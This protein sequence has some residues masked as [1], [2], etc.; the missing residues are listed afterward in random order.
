MYR[1]YDISKAYNDIRTQVGTGNVVAAGWSSLIIHGAA[2]SSCAMYF[3]VSSSGWGIL[4][5]DIP[6]SFIY[7]LDGCRMAKLPG[8]IW[9]YEGMYISRE[10]VDG[11]WVYTME[12]METRAKLTRKP[13]SV[14]WADSAQQLSCIEMYK[15]AKDAAVSR[16]SSERRAEEERLREREARRPKTDGESEDVKKFEQSCLYADWYYSYS[17]DLNAYRSGKAECEALEK[18]ARQKGGIYLRLY[19]FYSKK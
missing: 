8:D 5:K 14:N 13:G 16:K 17:D 1:K 9:I 12:S 2:D 4:T 19:E 15:Q 7:N 10:V 18:E 11:I 3:D 6:D